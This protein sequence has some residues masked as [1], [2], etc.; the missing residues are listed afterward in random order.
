MEFSEIFERGGF[1]IVV[2]N[3]P[4]VRQEAYPRSKGIV[5]GIL[6]GYLPG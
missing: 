6:S 1:D 5:Q 4:Y 2:G 3:P